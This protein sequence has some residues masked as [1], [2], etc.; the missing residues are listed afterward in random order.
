MRWFA[1]LALIA[2]L[3]PVA[4]VAQEDDR[5]YLTAFLEDNLSSA[6]RQVIIT[7]FRGALSSQANHAIQRVPLLLG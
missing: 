2:A 7:G 4:V 5:S 6:G 3:V 1:R